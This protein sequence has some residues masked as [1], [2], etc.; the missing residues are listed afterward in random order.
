[1]SS[2]VMV[3]STESSKRLPGERIMQYKERIAFKDWKVLRFNY[4]CSQK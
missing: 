3:E 2:S 1:M 4:I